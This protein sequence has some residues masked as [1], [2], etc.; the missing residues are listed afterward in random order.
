MR[1]FTKQPWELFDYD[2]ELEDYF[3]ERDDQ[4]YLVDIAATSV[5]PF[6]ALPEIELGPDPL[7]DTQFLPGRGGL[8]RRGK[9]W[10]GGGL[11]KIDYIITCK[12]T[13]FLGRQEELE[14]KIRVRETP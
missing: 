4:D 3:D 8:L 2:I 12:I 11:D 13:T 6:G 14:F 5:P 9:V 10:I 7:P 1:T